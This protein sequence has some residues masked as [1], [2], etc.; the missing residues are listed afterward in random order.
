VDQSAI[1]DCILGPSGYGAAVF[2]YISFPLSF[3]TGK[4]IK[5]PAYVFYCFVLKYVAYN[6]EL[7]FDHIKPQVVS[8]IS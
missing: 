8:V 6:R 4:Y 7:V 1:H 5:P 3:G 2:G